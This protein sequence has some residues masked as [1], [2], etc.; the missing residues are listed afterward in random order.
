MRIL[1]WI[2]GSESEGTDGQ[3]GE[4]QELAAHVSWSVRVRAG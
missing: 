3:K 4:G 2:L 1:S